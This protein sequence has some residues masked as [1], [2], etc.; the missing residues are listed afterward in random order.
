VL[1][2]PELRG[3][4][5][6]NERFTGIR[7]YVGHNPIA[8]TTHLLPPPHFGEHTV[9]ILEKLLKISPSELKSLTD[10]GIIR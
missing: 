5:I 10:K 7:T 3:L 1:E 8:K 4:F 6:E 2:D 9:S